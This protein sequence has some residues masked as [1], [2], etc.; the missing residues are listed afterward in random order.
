MSEKENYLIFKK[1]SR[2]L[3]AVIAAINFILTGLA[4]MAY[5]PPAQLPTPIKELFVVSILL[6]PSLFILSLYYLIWK[7]CRTM[8]MFVC[9]GMSLGATLIVIK[10]IM[11]S[12][13]AKS[14][15]NM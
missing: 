4:L 13:N 2:A 8:W 10:L 15:N 5:R 9:L 1:R 11:A 12:V 6:S 7:R 3:L 14:Q